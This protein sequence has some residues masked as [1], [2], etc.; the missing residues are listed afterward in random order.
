MAKVDRHKPELFRSGNLEK[1]KSKI[2]KLVFLFL[3][4]SVVEILFSYFFLGRQRVFFLFFFKP[5][6]YK[7]PPQMKT[8]KHI[9][10]EHF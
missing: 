3:V 9:L 5:F 1:K 8:A 2:L 4:D 7:F 6:F 10:I